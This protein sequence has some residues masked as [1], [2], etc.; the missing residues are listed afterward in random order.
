MLKTQ[1][2]GFPPKPLERFGMDIAVH[3]EMMTSGGE[4]LANREHIDGVIAHV[5]HHREDLVVGLAQTNH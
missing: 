1:V 5:A 4:I 2:L 3:R